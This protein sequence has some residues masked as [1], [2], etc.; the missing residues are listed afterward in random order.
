[1][2]AGSGNP[3]ALVFAATHSLMRSCGHGYTPSNTTVTVTLATST[4]ALS[5]AR[6]IRLFVPEA[7]RKVP[8][9]FETLNQFSV[10]ARPLTVISFTFNGAVPVN[11]M[12][13]VALVP[14]PV[15]VN[16]A[17]AGICVSR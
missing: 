3:L 10:M 11:V 5:R 7:M 6:T 4:P 1:M 15:A 2:S 16:A 9:Q 12:T 8:L 17:L 14:G 13:F